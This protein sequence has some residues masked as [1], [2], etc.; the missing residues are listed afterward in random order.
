M[1]EAERIAKT[2]FGVKKLSV[3]SAVGTREYYKKLGYVQ[4]GPYVSKVL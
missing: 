4:N 2:E 3:I 1:W